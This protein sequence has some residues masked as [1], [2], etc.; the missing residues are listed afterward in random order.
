MAWKVRGLWDS[1][2]MAEALY[3]LAV[4]GAGPAGCAAAVE[5]ARAG[6]RVLQIERSRFPREKICGDCV[7]PAVWPWLQAL[8][9]DREMAAGGGRQLRQVVFGRVDGREHRVALPEREGRAEV[10][11]R[12]SVFDQILARRVGELGVDQR[13][14]CVLTALGEGRNWELVTREGRFLARMMV[15]A[16]GRN[17]TVASLLRIRPRKRDRRVAFQAHVQ[18][19]DYETESVQLHLHRTGYVGFADVGEGWTNVCLVSLP[20]SSMAIRKWAVDRFGVPQT[21]TWRSISP[22]ART[23]LRSPHP[24]LLLAGDARRV[25]EP[26]T[27]EGIYYG[28]ASGALAGRAV[29]A[30]L[31]EGEEDVRPQFEKT[32][33]AI[34]GGRLWWNRLAYL[35]VTRPALGSVIVAVAAGTGWLGYLTSK[36]VAGR[37][38]GFG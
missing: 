12:R 3:D 25:V 4:V 37:G 15:A 9:V 28:V 34:Y 26:F 38:T 6:L 2:E 31:R 21:A 36:V 30:A 24:R 10:G 14:G 32:W 8:G 20:R 17:S 7:N 1:E 27:G 5:A 19:P 29:V 33:R 23:D 13:F 11:V 18:M 16:D 22:I 35:A